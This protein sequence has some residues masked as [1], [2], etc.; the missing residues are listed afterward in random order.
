[1]YGG[2]S[3]SISLEKT[4][5]SD[6]ILGNNTPMKV[7]GKGKANLDVKNTKVANI[8]LVEGSKHNILRWVK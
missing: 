8:L 1:M 7:I 2:E 6:V 5:G 3:R 4:K